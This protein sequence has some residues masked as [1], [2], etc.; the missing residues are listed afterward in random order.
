MESSGFNIKDSHVRIQERM[1]NLFVIVI[2]ADVLC[3]LI[4]VYIHENI[5]EIVF[6]QTS[7][8]IKSSSAA[9]VLSQSISSGSILLLPQ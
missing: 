9:A 6:F 4:G 3:C 8:F 7:P 5:K 2:I 1:V